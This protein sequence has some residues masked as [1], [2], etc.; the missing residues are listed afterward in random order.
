MPLMDE[1]RE[2]REAI[3]HGTPAEKYQYFKD[4]Y[5]T[6]L[7]IAV[8]A[9]IIVGSFIYQYVAHKETAFY[10]LM[11]NCSAYPENDWF[12][13]GYADKVSISLDDYEIT[14]DSAV[15]L[16]L[17]STFEDS[18]IASQKIATYSGAGHVDVMMG[19][20]DEFAYYANNVTFKDLR[21]ILTEEQLAKYEPYF[22]Y[23]DEAI[24]EKIS[25][26]VMVAGDTSELSF[27]D[28]RDPDSMERPVPVAIYI[29]SSKKLNEAYYFKNAEDGIAIGVFANAPHPEN[30]QAFIDYLM[31]E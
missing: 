17:D 24:L 23:F 30:V 12:L 5:R 16:D 20:G 26:D 4:Y 18:Q 15:Y 21:D 27:P 7:I 28:P 9:L 22:Y 25:E 2:E 29:D 19:G 1:F 13:E 14:L 3:K 10:A 11:L 6:P 31:S 8:I